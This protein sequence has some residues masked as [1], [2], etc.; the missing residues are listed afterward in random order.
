MSQT[1]ETL[2][3]RLAPVYDLIYGV[4]LAPGRRHAMARLAPERGET[5]LEVGVGTGLSAITYPLGCRV[6]AI[7]ISPP[8]LRR[9]RARLARR[10][11]GHVAL[12]RMDATRL[13]FPDEQFDAIY[14]PYVVNVVPDPVIA[15]R[16]MARVCRKRGRIV[17]LNHF[18]YTRDDRPPVDRVCGHFAS[19][20]GVNWHLDLGALLEGAGLVARSIEP[21]NVP[22]VSS[23]VVCHRKL[24]T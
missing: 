7:D 11:V 8:M 14:A 2:Y 10:G 21:V 19:R 3:Q 4:T 20:I 13:A 12:C 15:A 9:A 17:F 24:R 16:E 22:R 6:I 5:I 1:V 18:A 23:V